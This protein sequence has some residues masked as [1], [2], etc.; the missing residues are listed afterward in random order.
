MIKLKE[1]LNEIEEACWVKYKQVGMKLKD[2]EPVPNCVKKEGFV[3]ISSF[4]A[5]GFKD[6]FT[7]NVRGAAFNNTQISF[8]GIPNYSTIESYMQ[9]GTELQALPTY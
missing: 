9:V 8:D 2:G 4:N 5:A 1:L 7:A 3:N 6:T